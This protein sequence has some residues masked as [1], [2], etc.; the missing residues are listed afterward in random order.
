MSKMLST[1]LKFLNFRLKKLL[2]GKMS[3]FRNFILVSLNFS[4]S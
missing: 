1:A 3:K 4:I 2:L